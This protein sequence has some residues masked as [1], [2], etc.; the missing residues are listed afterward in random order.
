MRTPLCVCVCV[1]VREGGP[2][3]NFWT[4]WPIFNDIWYESYATEGHPNVVIF[5]FP[6]SL[7]TYYGEPVTLKDGSAITANETEGREIV[8]NNV[9]S[10]DTQLYGGTFR[11]TWNNNVTVAGRIVFSFR[12]DGY[13]LR[14]T[15]NRHFKIWYKQTS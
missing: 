15:G 5:H 11:K 1:C 3:F 8:H 13:S 2:T 4:S 10:K 14:T 6:Q 12:F 9:S 7:I